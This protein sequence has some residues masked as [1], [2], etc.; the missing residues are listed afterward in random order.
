MT[1][2]ETN[3][4]FDQDQQA[5]QAVRGGDAERYRELV[6]RHERR[7]F[8]V[9]WSRLGDAAL[10]EE[11]AQESFI[12]AY[13]RLWL[14]GDGAKFSAWIAAITRRLAINCGLRNRRELNKRR[15]W[16]LEQTASPAD[17]SAELCPPETLRQAL[18]DLP[19]KHR[20]CLVLF[21]LEGK[22]G[23]EAASAL[24]ISETALR[25]RLHRARAALREQLDQRLAESLEQLRPSRPLA[26]AV[27]GTILTSSSAKM[28]GGVGFGAKILSWFLPFK[29]LTW[30]FWAIWALPMLVGMFLR[31]KTIGMEQS[32]F[33]DAAGFRARLYQDWSTRMVWPM[34]GLVVAVQVLMISVVCLTLPIYGI[35][36][37]Y[38]AIAALLLPIIFLSARR[39]AVC[40]NR[41]HIATLVSCLVMMAGLLLIGL[42]LLPVSAFSVCMALYMITVAV[43]YGARPLRMD[44]NLFLRASQNLLDAAPVESGPTEA[45]HKLDDSGLRAFA[46]FLG[47]RWLVAG[48]RW[49]GSRLI[50]RL[51][52]FQA[53]FLNSVHYV[54]GHQ[55]SSLKLDENGCVAAHLGAKDEQ[56][57]LA[58]H[59]RTSPEALDLEIRVAASVQSAWRHFRRGDI[60]AAK[61]AIG[62]V[63]DADVF[64]VPTARSK[65]TRWLCI[66]S[67]SLAVVSAV[68]MG[69]VWVFPERLSGQKPV[70]VTEAQVRSFLNDIA[71]NPDPRKYKFN[72][73][74]IALQNCLVLPPSNLFSP[75]GLR[76][77]RTNL[78]VGSGWTPQ[79]KE[80]WK[81][82]M[83]CS[84]HLARRAIVVGVNWIGWDDVN[85]KPQDVTKYIH[86]NQEANQLQLK[87]Q[88]LLTG[89]K[90]WSW[91]DNKGWDVLRAGSFTLSQ[92]RWLRELNCLDLVDRAKLIQQIASV[93][94]LSASVP[95]GQ[96]TLHNWRDVR[97]LFF[98]PCWPA[99]QDT[100][101]S[102]ASLEILG[103]LDKIDRE[104]CIR[105][106]L[107]RHHGKG[108]FDS[109]SSGSYNEYK[110][111]GSERDTIA[112]FE[113][114]RILGALDRV[115]DLDKWQFRLSSFRSSKPD[116]NGARTL[117]WDEVEAWV[118]QQRLE[119]DLAEHQQNPGAPWRSLLEP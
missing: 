54:F 38:L 75:E 32:N 61:R 116:V 108:F 65:S 100:Y 101:Y 4:S 2:T 63:P 27:M 76:A 109:P 106:I 84:S 78:L 95:P 79:I 3:S 113:S 43:G 94:A 112:A 80:E 41:F 104:A 36:R 118:C 52:P 74:A 64:I 51:P 28:A 22:S 86:E 105:G 8:A 60:A 97:G 1:D 114:L 46:R 20:E 47:A 23:A 119:R 29:F 33:R 45:D 82:A 81:T 71:P 87:L 7:V 93:Q 44:Y 6:E 14:L 59:G 12:R 17:E 110:I 55:G 102:V 34:L 73:P 11:V 49:Q 77:M 10:A 68:I 70:S 66:V 117:S 90:A 39:L 9:A 103:G 40:C 58:L 42:G 35:R 15:R 107:R 13:R 24:G 69:T 98:T 89:E 96:P 19:A 30:F 72:D 111:D 115:K 16:A 5:V 85:L 62:E 21:Y 92:L 50:L 91:V 88:F 37:L 25:V 67:C 83:L 31:I 53:S 18:A 56:D 57:L 48:H 26:S 99:L